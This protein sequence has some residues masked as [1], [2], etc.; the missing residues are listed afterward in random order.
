MSVSL[1]IPLFFFSYF[2]FL[3]FASCCFICF[4]ALRYNALPEPNKS[5]MTWLMDVLADAAMFSSN[6]MTPRNFGMLASPPL[7]NTP[8]IPFPPLPFL[9]LSSLLLSLPHSI[10]SDMRGPQSV[11]Q[12]RH[13]PRRLSLHLRQSRPFR[14]PNSQLPTTPQDTT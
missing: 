12:H 4:D 13:Q 2:F 10:C 14:F 5:L 9:L 11:H 3:S 6:K 7:H 1:C 8:S